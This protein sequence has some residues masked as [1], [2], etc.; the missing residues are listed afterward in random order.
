[1]NIVKSFSTFP[2]TY[3]EIERFSSIYQPH[4]LIVIY[5]GFDEEKTREIIRF[6]KIKTETIHLISMDNKE[7]NKTAKQFQERPYQE[8]I[9]KKILS[10]QRYGFFCRKYTL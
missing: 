6:T 7:K 10:T 4:E 2:T 9:F 3:D 8:E 5:S 1:M